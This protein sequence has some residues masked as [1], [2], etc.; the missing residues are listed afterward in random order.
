MT[1][2]SVN[3]EMS[4]WRIQEDHIEEKAKPKIPIKQKTGQQSPHLSRRKKADFYLCQV[5][6][7]YPLLT[8]LRLTESIHAI[9]SALY[10]LIEYHGG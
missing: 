8:A 9:L 5:Y 1:S 6:T 3:G 2:E 4:E 7:H 10:K